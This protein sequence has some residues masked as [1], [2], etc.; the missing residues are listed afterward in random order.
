[1]R[2]LSC[3]RPLDDFEATR[4]YESAPTV[5]L[6]LCRK[7]SIGLGIKTIDRDDLDD[8][9]NDPIPQEVEEPDQVDY[10]SVSTADEVND[11]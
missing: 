5:Y 8:I 4:K 7:C 11:Y 1:M 9:S 6:E 10:S 3:N 2:C